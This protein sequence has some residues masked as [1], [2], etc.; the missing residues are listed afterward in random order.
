MKKI[1]NLCP[2]PFALLL[3][4]LSIKFITSCTLKEEKI[5]P[6]NSL[7]RIN[8]NCSNFGYS[9]TLFFKSNQA[10]D[11]IVSPSNSQNGTYGGF[12]EGLSINPSTGVINV[13]MS[14]AGL[15]YKV[16]FVPANTTDTCFKF[17][18]ISGVDY[19]S[20]IY[21]L[22][23]ND[24]IA[25]PNYRG[26]NSVLPCSDDDE[27]DDDDNECEFDD[28][29]DDDDGDGTGDE[30]PT[31]QEVILQGVDIDKVTGKIDLKKSIQNGALGINPANGTSKLF[32]IYYRLN[33]NSQKA[34]NFIDV[35]IH[36]FQTL[37]AIPQSLLNQIADK[38]NALMVNSFSTNRNARFKYSKPRP[39]DI[40]VIGYY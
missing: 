4:L 37:G 3:L 24:E 30:P 22:D 26:L 2:Q 36:Y 33:D 27:D 28:G 14:E 7:E 23:N 31:G 8:T 25:S 13:T 29:N 5:V 19:L 40:I 10:T 20:K 17:I 11:F 15:R 12:P 16:Y 32:R 9:D 1:L 39:P 6:Q 34:L 35:K 38:N 21:N 18:T